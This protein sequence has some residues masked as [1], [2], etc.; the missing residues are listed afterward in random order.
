MSVLSSVNETNVDYTGVYA[1]PYGTT[2]IA[3][4]CFAGTSRIEVV[5]VPKTVEKIGKRAFDGC[6]ALREVHISGEAK[7][8]TT[9]LKD[10]VKVTYQEKPRVL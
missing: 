6:S 9:Y 2:E 7:V 3:D 4:G 10:G 5:I 8:D 1:V